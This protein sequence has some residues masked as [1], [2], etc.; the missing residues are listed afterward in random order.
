MNTTQTLNK[1]NLKCKIIKDIFTFLSQSIYL[2]NINFKRFKNVS[3]YEKSKCL[4]I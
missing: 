2:K 1:Y 4:I 3:S